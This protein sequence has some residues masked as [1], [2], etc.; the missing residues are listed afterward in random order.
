MFMYVILF[1]MSYCPWFGRR[2]TILLISWELMLLFSVTVIHSQTYLGFLKEWSQKRAFF[3]WAL[4]STELCVTLQWDINYKEVLSGDDNCYHSW[5]GCH[6]LLDILRLQKSDFF[7][8]SKRHLC[9]I[10]VVCSPQ[11]AIY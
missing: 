8:Y 3:R 10:A 7:L 1:I 6:V 2:D 9:K 11:W 5:R 4:F